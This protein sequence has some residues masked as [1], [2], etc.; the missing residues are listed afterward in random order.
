MAD[1]RSGVCYSIPIQNYT[2]S[3]IISELLTVTATYCTWEEI[4]MQK[5]CHFIWLFIV[6]AIPI[7]I[8]IKL[9]DD[10]G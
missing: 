7:K 3:A 10:R 4:R 1:V 6:V 2:Y 5:F 8:S 9:Y